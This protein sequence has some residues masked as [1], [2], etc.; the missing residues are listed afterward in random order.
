MV[1]A[2]DWSDFWIHEAVDGYMQTLYIEENL[3]DRSPSAFMMNWKM[4]KNEQ[5]VAPRKEMTSNEAYTNDM[6]SKG[7]YVLHTLRY[8]VGDETFKLI[9]RRWAYP[10]PKMEEIE[11]GG[12]C[13]FTTTDEFLEIAEKVSD[14]KLDWFWEVYFRQASLPVLNT[15]IIDDT[16]YLEWQIENNIEFPLPVEIQIGEEV[17]KVEM[18]EGTGSL[19]I[20]EEVE[21]IIDPNKWITMSDVEIIRK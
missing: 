3:P 8:Y 15:K 14:K 2:K 11:W 17:V 4:W 6:Y 9:L 5:P 13:R 20:P 19:K 16:L 18:K 21:P 1:T 12:Q 7:S 10:D